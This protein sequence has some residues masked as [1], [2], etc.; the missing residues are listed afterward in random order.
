[1]AS[2]DEFAAQGLIKASRELIDSAIE[3]MRLLSKSQVTPI[4]GIDLEELIGSLVDKLNM[5]SSIE[6]TFDYKLYNPVME[7]D[8]KLN[9]YRIIQ[10]QTNNILKHAN[11]SNIMI[12]LNDNN[13]SLYIT[14]EDD[15]NG[16]DLGQKRKGIGLTNMNNRVESFNGEFKIESSPGNGCKL[17]IKIPY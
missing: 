16:F 5:V 7:D 13:G 9:I 8:L 17:K 11:A 2:K 12:L 10:E 6:T 3:E 1:M 4:K 14:I 15:G